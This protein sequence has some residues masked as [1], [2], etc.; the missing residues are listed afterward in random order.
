MFLRVEEES[1]RR[2]QLEEMAEVTA[3]RQATPLPLADII[4]VF[5]QPGDGDEDTTASTAKSEK[6]R[7]RGSLSVSRFGQVRRS[8]SPLIDIVVLNGLHPL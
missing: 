2:A 3:Q 5:Q 6:S 4:P 8:W 1:E 7:R